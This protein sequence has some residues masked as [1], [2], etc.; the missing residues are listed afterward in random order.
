[1]ITNTTIFTG[2]DSKYWKQYGKSFVKSFKHFNPNT[3]V[4]IQ[5]FNPDSNDLAELNSLDCKYKVETIDQ[6]YIDRLT[7]AHLNIFSN[8]LDEDLKS[9]LNFGMK[10]SEKNYGFVTLEDKMRHLITFAVYASFRFIRLAEL[11]DGKNPVAAYD[12]DTICQ[13]EINIDEMLGLNDAGCLSVKGDRLVVSLVAFRNNNQL[14]AEW[15]ASLQHSF[16]SNRV[17]GFLD[18][19]TFIHCAANYNITPIDK[20]FCDHTKKS[21]NACVITGKGNTKWSERFQIA[22]SRWLN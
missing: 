11:W 15:G 10:F 6:S 1:M 19:D 3:D 4:F 20:K 7:N 8:N 5:I 17:Y 21:N 22:Q 13:S 2:G 16:N 12:M 18:Q 14:L 9:K